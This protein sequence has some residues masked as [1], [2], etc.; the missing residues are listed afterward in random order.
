MSKSDDVIS[1]IVR[2]LVKDRFEKNMDRLEENMK[3][4]YKGFRE[5]YANPGD[6]EG[7]AV[8][9]ALGYTKA[10]LDSIKGIVPNMPEDEMGAM[11][12]E[13]VKSLKKRINDIIDEITDL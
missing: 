3:D 4:I 5:M 12:K 7:F 6:K 10:Y 2:A 13:I 1:Y 11:E 9:Y 8:G